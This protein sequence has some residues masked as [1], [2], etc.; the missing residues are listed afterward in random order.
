MF[1]HPSESFS[2]S[3]SFTHTTNT[4]SEKGSFPLIHF[5]NN[6]CPN[7]IFYKVLYNQGWTTEHCIAI[8]ARQ[9]SKITLSFLLSCFLVCRIRNSWSPH[10]MAPGNIAITAYHKVVFPL[11]V[12][13]KETYWGFKPIFLDL[14]APEVFLFA[15]DWLCW[16]A[17]F[18]DQ[19]Q[20]HD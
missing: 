13:C 19:T 4:S 8:V 18:Q 1:S 20:V 15:T 5:E 16:V 7:R 10:K 12:V 3:Q 6:I 2:P 17:T 11:C 14:C 9:I